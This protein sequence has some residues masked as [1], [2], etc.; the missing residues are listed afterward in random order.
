[1][2]LLSRKLKVIQCFLNMF[3]EKDWSNVNVVLPNPQKPKESVKIKGEMNDIVLGNYFELLNRNSGELFTEI[4][5][6]VEFSK[7]CYTLNQ[8][9]GQ[10]NFTFYL[11]Y[12]R[13]PR[14]RTG[15]GRVV[16]Y[17]DQAVKLLSQFVGNPMRTSSIKYSIER[18]AN[19]IRF[20]LNS[21]S[22]EDL[23]M[24]DGRVA[25]FLM[26]VMQL[27]INKGHYYP[28]RKYAA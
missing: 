3:D 19:T 25:M 7:P 8:D 1:M 18:S 24:C 2:F 16:D 20:N 4:S 28:A 13:Q 17:V 14:P 27:Q 22:M 9:N 11:N 21:P 26:L 23:W 15:R 5:K 12:V 6:Y 10:Y